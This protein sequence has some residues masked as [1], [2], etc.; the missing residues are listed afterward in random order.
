MANIKITDLPAVTTPLA[1]TEVVEI[2]Q[3]GSSKK[4]TAAEVASAY[5]GTLPVANGGTGATTISAARTALGL[6]TMATQ[7]ASAVAITGGT[8]PFNAT[9]GRA[10]ASFYDTADQ[11]GSPS[12]AAAVRL[13][14]VDIA[15]AG[16]TM[17][18]DGSALTR[19]TFAVA[20]TYMVAPSIQFVNSDANDHDV[21]IWFALGGTNIA[22]STT[23][24]TIPKAADGGAGYFQ[25]VFYVA[26]T[27]GQYVQVMWLPETV[28]VTIDYTAASAGPPPVPATPSVI[29]VA[30]RIA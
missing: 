9:T 16:I 6:G 23:R 18:T 21:K 5:A 29:L 3:G 12:A 24:I 26:V 10:Y 4:A 30:E 1:G 28:A 17:V 11:T 2:V 14:T 27:A 8:I 15:G 13:N 20:G 7:D 22:N 25:V 19:L